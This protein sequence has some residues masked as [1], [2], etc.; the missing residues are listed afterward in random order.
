MP[1]IRTMSAGRAG[2]TAYNT[3]VNANTGGGNKKQGLSTTTN[4][5]INSSNA[6]KN[7]AY[8][9]NRDFVFCVNQL[10]GI[11]GKSK[12]FATTADGVKDCITGP[13]GC[14]QIVREAFLE[15]LNREPDQGGLRTYCLA[16]KKRGFTKNDVIADILQSDEA[17]NLYKT[18]YI[19]TH[20]V[21]GVKLAELE[22]GG[23]S[24]KITVAN[25]YAKAH[26]GMLPSQV[27]VVLLPGSVKIVAT[28]LLN[29][30]D[31]L[32][33]NKEVV[34][35][36]ILEEVVSATTSGALTIQSSITKIDAKTPLSNRKELVIDQT[37]END[38]IPNLPVPTIVIVNQTNTS[39]NHTIGEGVT[40]DNDVSLF[41]KSITHDGH[42][43]LSIPSGGQFQ[44]LVDGIYNLVYEARNKFGKTTEKTL[45]LTVDVTNPLINLIGDDKIRL[46]QGVTYNVLGA[47][48]SDNSTLFGGS[49]PIIT[50]TASTDINT[51]VLGLQSY[52]Y[53]AV[54]DHGNSNTIKRAVHVH[55][56]TNLRSLSDVIEDMQLNFGR[57]KIT[58]NFIIPRD[59]TRTY[60]LN[61]QYGQTAFS[62]GGVFMSSYALLNVDPQT[63]ENAPWDEVKLK[64]SLIARYSP[65]V[66][67]SYEN[68][69]SIFD[70]ENMTKSDDLNLNNFRGAYIDGKDFYFIELSCNKWEIIYD[71]GSTNEKILT[72]TI[73]GTKEQ[74][75]LNSDVNLEVEKGMVAFA[76]GTQGYAGNRIVKKNDNNE[77]VG[78]ESF[79]LKKSIGGGPAVVHTKTDNLITIT[80]CGEYED[81]VAIADSE[82]TQ[83]LS[84]Q[85]FT[86][87]DSI[88]IKGISEQA[89]IWK[90][91]RFHYSTHGYP[92]SLHIQ[93]ITLSTDTINDYAVYS[94]PKYV[95]DL[96]KNNN[97]HHGTL[98][99]MRNVTIEGYSGHTA[100]IMTI[101]DWVVVKDQ[102]GKNIPNDRSVRSW[103]EVNG[104]A[105][106]IRGPI[107]Y[108]NQSATTPTLENVT[109]RNCCRGIRFQEVTGA[110]VKDC[111]VNNVS[112]NAFYF[113][114]G[115]YA[116]DKGCENCTFDSC[117][118]EKVG[119]A[120]LNNIGGQNNTFK[121]CTVKS[122]RASA[123]QVYH[124]NSTI[125]FQNCTI[126]DANKAE[127][128]RTPWGGSADFSD[129]G[130]AVG[131]KVGPTSTTNNLDKDDAKVVV[132]GSKFI[133][134]GDSVFYKFHKETKLEISDTE[135]TEADFSGGI[136][137][138]ATNDGTYPILPDGTGGPTQSQTL[139]GITWGAENTPTALPSS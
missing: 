6:I 101:D 67:S 102:N 98:V 99:T 97:S 44:G 105:M 81:N 16:M 39:G 65:P 35:K 4:K 82:L 75:I 118:A 121:N 107:T 3:N 85:N 112:D 53:K 12:M 108:T 71:N 62:T 133:S 51:N 131:I 124:S 61:A 109:I 52:Y 84:D 45:I 123:I 24:L 22:D 48:A 30:D 129:I 40:K 70:Y 56:P 100:D 127:F 122:T 23:E 137:D 106:R 36:K 28:I 76:V 74:P 46:T 11:G 57:N 94:K 73:G 17:K 79:T 134:G 60:V 110:Y 68:K 34:A 116:S 25:E 88:I 138:G 89:S 125:T 21:K 69:L 86:D 31:D 96:S 66:T 83:I 64:N 117:H 126:E 9:Q 14:E 41:L 95:D 55:P 77:I 132:D 54:D 78:V 37:N 63:S 139:E 19:I 13:Y 80:I 42:G 7:R 49:L 58:E 136:I 5:G 114:S 50:N 93:D 1:K 59:M 38:A 119:Q 87:A 72:G 90:N 27:S 15:A 10:G 20:T 32:N 33:P 29:P 115:S 113:A 8:G 43:E 18:E 120:G 103:S 130:A 135:I 92:K 2:A 47:I 104:G 128:V 91:F 26:P 111:S